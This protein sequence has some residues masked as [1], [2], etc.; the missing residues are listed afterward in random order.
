MKGLVDVLLK[1]DTYKYCSGHVRMV[2]NGMLVLAQLLEAVA[3]W[4]YNGLIEM[5]AHGMNVH[6][7]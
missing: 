4:N 7:L 3:I 6:V 1:M 2:V 5:A